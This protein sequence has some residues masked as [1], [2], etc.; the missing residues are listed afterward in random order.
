[1]W[2]TSLIPQECDTKKWKEYLWQDFV[3]IWQGLIT[4]SVNSLQG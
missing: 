2:Q 4:L 1:M 3:G